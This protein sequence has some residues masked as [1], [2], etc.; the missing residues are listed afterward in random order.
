MN[1]SSILTRHR[2]T[3]ELRVFGTE[4]SYTQSLL[5]EPT[6]QSNDLALFRLRIVERIIRSG[7]APLL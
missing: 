4:T 5:E 6:P 7:V 3:T 1:L 2:S